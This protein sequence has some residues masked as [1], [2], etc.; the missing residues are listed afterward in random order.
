MLAWTLIAIY[1]ISF[2]YAWVLTQIRLHPHIIK[3]ESI[4]DHPNVNT[5]HERLPLIAFNITCVFATAIL[6]SYFIGFM[7]NF[8]FD[9]PW[10][11]IALQILFMAML[12]DMWFYYIHRF[13]HENAWVFRHIHSIH[14]RVRSTLPLDY[15][16]V[17]PLEWMIGGF[18]IP[19]ACLIIYFVLGN[20]SAYALF[21][22]GAFK[23]IHEINIH[24]GIKSWLLERHPLKFIGSSEHHGN[25][26]F[27]VKGNYASTFKWLDH[28]SKSKLS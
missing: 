17:H 12:D 2:L 11:S 25:H 23:V 5:F 22:F 27:K 14:H 1:G 10:W 18:G 9:I 7:F 26:H 28:I 21:L 6:S 24:S 4:Y 20:I 16:Y 19:I 3:T 13:A 8:S 15:I